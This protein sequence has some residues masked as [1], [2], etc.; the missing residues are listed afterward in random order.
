MGDMLAAV[1]VSHRALIDVCS[2]VWLVGIVS[3]NRIIK[4]EEVK[5]KK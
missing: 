5:E 4:K 3:D 1:Y 2:F